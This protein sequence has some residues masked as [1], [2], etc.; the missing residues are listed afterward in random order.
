MLEKLFTSKTRVDILDR[1]LLNSDSEYHIRAMSRIIN[2]T[3]ILVQKELNNL[4]QFGL[5][6]KRKMGKMILYRLNKRSV[7]AEDLKRIFLKT[8]SLGS[9]MLAKIN[10]KDKKKVRFAL[11]Y[12][13]FAKNV[14]TT[15]SDID[16]LVIGDIDEDS[17][18]RAIT[19]TERDLGRQLNLVMWTEQEFSEKM[20][21]KIPLVKELAKTPV[22]MIVGDSSEF[23]RLVK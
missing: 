13:S 19:K 9:Q 1:F 5:L 10:K 17:I 4:E 2:V 11:I 3:P 22:I 18:L 23:K 20:R 6:K 7:I 12:G 15:S 14:D 16:L 21:Q 8:E